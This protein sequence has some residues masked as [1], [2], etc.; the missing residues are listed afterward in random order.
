MKSSVFRTII[1]KQPILF[2]APHV[3]SHKRPQLSRAYKYGEP[4]T[5]IVVEQ[6]CDKTGGYGIML[7]AESDYDFNYHTEKDNP[8]KKRVREIVKEE[9]IKYFLDVHGL[10]D[11]NLYDVAIYYPTRFSKSMELARSLRKS[12]AKGV[13]RKTNIMIFRFLDN[14]QETLG[15]FV[16][17]QLR[18]P[19]VQI[20]IAR[21]IRE[22]DKLRD[23]LVENISKHF[24]EQV[25]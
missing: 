14:E 16:A 3:Y 21:Y 5:D 9:N 19:S 1:G 6:L 24:N 18:V 17:S 23:A 4:F 7:T 15:K 11:G 12:I 25:V 13:L 8:Y 22:S 10:K 20:E 2:S